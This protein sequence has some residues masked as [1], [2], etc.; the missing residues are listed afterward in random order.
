MSSNTLKIVLNALYIITLLIVASIL[1]FSL[2]SFITFSIIPGETYKKDEIKITSHNVKFVKINGINFAIATPEANPCQVILVIHGWGKSS[3]NMLFT[4]NLMNKFATNSIFILVDLPKH[5][6]SDNPP[7]F[8]FGP[9]ETAAVLNSFLK[10]RESYKLDNLPLKI[11]GFS[12]GADIAVN[13]AACLDKLGIKVKAVFAEAPFNNIKTVIRHYATEVLKLKFE[14]A[15]DTA[16]Y[17]YKIL[18]KLVST[19][20]H[21]EKTVSSKLPSYYLT[22]SLSWGLFPK[23]NSE[24]LKQHGTHLFIFCSETD[25]RTPCHYLKDAV[26]VFRAN[27]GSLFHFTKCKGADHGEAIEYKEMIN[28]IKTFCLL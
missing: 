19:G 6:L 16:C 25:S 27:L 14:I 18:W 24:I 28:L 1:T 8:S 2:S 7:F 3:K 9:V 22:P 23:E 21:L 4:V 20:T 5:G 11:L 10:L 15:G 17:L 13:L 12:V 26:E